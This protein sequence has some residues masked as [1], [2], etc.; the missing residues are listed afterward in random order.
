MN[1]RTLRRI[2]TLAESAIVVYWLAS[3]TIIVL[4]VLL[5]YADGERHATREIH[6]PVNT[7]ETVSGRLESGA[8][9]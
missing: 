8:G 9:K 1:T 6:V 5:L 4:V 7:I 2:D 3:I